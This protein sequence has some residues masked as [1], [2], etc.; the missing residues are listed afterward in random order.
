MIWPS[1]EVRPYADPQVGQVRSISLK[2]K[3]LRLGF[4]I[5]LCR[6]V[7]QNWWEFARQHCN[8]I[9]FWI[10]AC[11][12]TL[13]RAVRYLIRL[14]QFGFITIFLFIQLICG[15]LIFWL[16]FLK[17]SANG[18]M[19]NNF[20]AGEF[21]LNIECNHATLSGH[22]WA[23]LR[24]EPNLG[25]FCNSSWKHFGTFFLI[26][27]ISQQPFQLSSWAWNC[28]DKRNTRKYRCKYGR[29]PDW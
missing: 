13:I 10:E 2:S 17:K 8:K 22:R 26:L 16:R 25:R 18:I 28:K 5:N 29:S 7:F 4:Q 19:Y 27:G 21:K 14:R 20:G 9:W 1:T 23:L 15:S 6:V 11:W 12:L 24:N 3:H